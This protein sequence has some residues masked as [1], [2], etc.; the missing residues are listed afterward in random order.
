MFRGS[1]EKVLQSPDP[2]TLA[3]LRVFD[4]QLLGLGKVEG[5]QLQVHIAPLSG[6]DVSVFSRLCVRGSKKI[7]RAAPLEIS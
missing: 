3:Q 1:S 2:E 5:R 6:G 7:F 4:N